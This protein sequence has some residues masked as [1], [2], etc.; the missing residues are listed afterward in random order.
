[1][2]TYLAFDVGG[3]SIKTALI[4]ADGQ[5]ISEIKRFPAKSD[6]TTDQIIDNFLHI[7]CTMADS[8]TQAGHTFHGIGIGFPGPF[9]YQKGISLMKGLN[10]YDS[11]YGVPLK[12]I[13]LSRLPFSTQIHFA[14]DADLY[15][16][17][18]C[19]FG[20]GRPFHRILAVC[21]GTGIGSGF[22]A[23]GK[24]VKK[25]LEVPENGWIYK[26]PYQDSIVDNYVS[27]TG[28]RRMIHQNPYL[29][30]ILDV[31]ELADAAQLGNP[32]ALSLF[33]EFGTM[34]AEI[35]PTFIQQ[36]HADALI[37]GGDV[38]KSFPLFSSPI[39]DLLA[40]TGVSVLPSKIFSDNSLL[41]ASILFE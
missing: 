23:D 24:L 2:K 25:G 33:Q 13:L 35:L 7:I 28:I 22:F 10:K 38:A 21:I 6:Q 39:K 37:I 1:M 3:S 16:M 14:N 26:T 31:K 34:L 12:D 15:C 18:E 8:A 40:S 17:G 5:F 27:A 29:T 4:T 20:V 11:I 19:T 30:N 41:A 36:F 32:Y 9:D